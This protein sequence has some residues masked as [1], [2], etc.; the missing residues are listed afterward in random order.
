MRSR[1]SALPVR[2]VRGRGLCAGGVQLRGVCVRLCV[3]AAEPREI[4][5]KRRAGGRRVTHCYMTIR[6]SVA[7]WMGRAGVT[8]W[9]SFGWVFIGN[10]LA[11][12]CYKML[13]LRGHP[14]I[15]MAIR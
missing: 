12:A 15:S 8:T 9:Y 11:R 7:V 5:G 2:A 3:P 13:Q 10:A 4:T 1:R 6:R 14:A